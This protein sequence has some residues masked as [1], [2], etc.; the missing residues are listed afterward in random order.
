MAIVFGH[1]RTTNN[2]TIKTYDPNPDTLHN[3]RDKNNIKKFMGQLNLYVDEVFFVTFLIFL[4]EKAN[5]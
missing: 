2:I 4:T 1:V 3:T 5:L